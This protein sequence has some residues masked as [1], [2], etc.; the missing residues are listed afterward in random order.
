MVFPYIHP[1]QKN[2]H[3]FFKKTYFDAEKSLVN[4]DTASNINFHS[5]V[6]CST[7][8]TDM[9]YST[10]L[11]K[12]EK[13][14]IERRKEFVFEAMGTFLGERRPQTIEEVSKNVEMG[15]ILPPLLRLDGKA[16]LLHARIQGR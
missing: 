15:L 11:C 8:P 9:R 14:F 6:F 4:N 1:G 13:K 16:W 5:F 12:E 7:A 10:D 3:I 2:V